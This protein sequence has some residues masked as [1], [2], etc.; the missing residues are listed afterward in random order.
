MLSVFGALVLFVCIFMLRSR[1]VQV[2]IT[3]II[4]GLDE[5]GIESLNELGRVY[6]FKERGYTPGEAQRSITLTD[7]SWQIKASFA[8]VMDCV[9]ILGYH[10]RPYLLFVGILGT[11]GYATIA[12]IPN[13]VSDS[14]AVLLF[15]LGVNAMVWNDTALDGFTMQKIKEYPAVDQELPSLQQVGLMTTAIVFS[16]ISGFL[17]EWVGLRWNYALVALISAAA[18]IAGAMMPEK[19]KKN[20]LKSS[21]ATFWTELRT[22]LSLFWLP[23]YLKMLV[24]VYLAAFNFDLT[25]AMVY[26]YEDVA[27]YSKGFIGTISTVG[28]AV[29]LIAVVINA[30]YFKKVSWRTLLIGFQLF[31]MAISALDLLLVCVAKDA[32]WGHFIALSDKAGSRAHAK[33]RFIV[34]QVAIADY[35]PETGETTATAILAMFMNFAGGFCGGYAGSFL[36]D[37]LNIEKGNYGNLPWAGLIRTLARLL[38]IPFIPFIIPAGCSADKIH[39][40]ASD[41]LKTNGDAAAA[42]GT[43]N[44][45]EKAL[46]LSPVSSNSTAQIV[47]NR[48][49]EPERTGSLSSS[50]S[51]FNEF[52]VA[53]N[54]D[55]VDDDDFDY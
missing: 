44:G 6:F 51:S 41:I 9:P 5:G 3:F 1:R 55:D 27:L 49:P 35:L 36:L 30:T 39:V 45:D 20:A 53:S 13:L 15:F 40:D 21:L 2:I 31:A 24:Y 29:A 23:P 11:A 37:A 54:T 14:V 19:R 25:T 16:F 12:A 28:W 18:T 34:V 38:P 52:F 43:E 7:L 50:S 48:V 47:V 33:L 22:I 26:W 42:N 46:E 8:L 17:I 10:Y 32:F 4:Y